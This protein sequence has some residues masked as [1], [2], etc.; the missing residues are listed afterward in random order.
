MPIKRNIITVKKEFIGAICAEMN[1]SRASVY[2]A[3]NYSTNSDTAQ[4]IRRLAIQNYGG[5][6]TKKVIW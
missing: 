5:I 4:K 1:V 6:E 2:N 3:L